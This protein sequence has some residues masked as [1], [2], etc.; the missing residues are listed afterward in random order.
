M[1]GMVYLGHVYSP[2]DMAIE[3]GRMTEMVARSHEGF[4]GGS[5]LQS[6]TQRFR[7]W[8][9]IIQFGLI[10]EGPG[11]MA[12]FLFGMAAVKSDIIAKPGAAL[13][14]RFRR[15]YL[16]IGLI[17]SVLGSYVMSQGENMLSPVS[18]GG[19]GL[20]AFFSLFLTA[21]YLGLIAKW[22]SSPP[23]KLKLFLGRGG[24]ATLTAYLLQGLILSL[25]FNAYGLGLFAEL[26]AAYCILIAFIVSLVTIG[27]A[28]LWRLYFARGPFEY[29]LRKF[30]YWA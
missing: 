30:T 12:F 10:L 2:E 22:A 8:G 9:E 25:I 5:F 23:G 11:A 29:G 26:N 15:V 27:F 7:E 6:V 21:G 16:P 3:L 1:S 14:R 17:G 19:M 28:S 18:M 13:W 4:G 24:T 20:I